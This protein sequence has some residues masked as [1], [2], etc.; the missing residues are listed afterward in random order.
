MATRYQGTF[1]ISWAQ[2]EVDGLAGTTVAAISVG[3]TWRWQG[4]AARVDNP[5]DVL[6]LRDSNDIEITRRLAA[7]QVQR[8]FRKLD[9]DLA[10][11]H[12]PDDDPPLFRSGFELTD[13][14]Q[15]YQVTLIE[16]AA[17]QYPMVLFEG[18]PPPCNTDLWVVRSNVHPLALKKPDGLGGIICFV[19]GTRINTPDG[20]RFVQ[21]LVEGDWISTKDNGRQ[22]VRWI[23]GRHMTGSRLLAMPHLRPIRLQANALAEGEP[24]GE[25]IVSPDHRVL[26][27]G[28]AAQ[29]LFNTAEVLVAA[30]DLINDASVRTDHRCREISYVHLMLDDHQIVWANGVEC[31]SFHP[32]S[33]RL[34]QIDAPQR[35]SLLERFPGIDDDPYSYG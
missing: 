11:A 13:G 1:V 6:I 25:L 10:A 33:A 28:P 17:T 24:D 15:K 14:Q 29:A 12:Q 4:T 21:D 5:R 34:D 3:S 16:V 8:A 19:P 9:R 20:P 32:A 18:P 35:L 22:A 2:T 31:E 23:G 26:I 7:R 30:R 27:K